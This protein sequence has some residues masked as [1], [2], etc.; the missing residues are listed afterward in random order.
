[1]PTQLPRPAAIQPEEYRQR[2][3]RL[4]AKLPSH[5]ALLVPGASLMTRSHDSEYPFRQQSD[6]YYL[7]GLQE[8][9]ALLLLLPGRAEGQSVVFCQ[10]RDPTLEAWTGRRLG[11]QGVVSQHGLDQAFENAE[12]DAL[13][14]TLLDGRELL[15]VPLDN[16]DALSIAEDALAYSQAGMRRGKPALKGWLDSRP[17][18][19]EM[20]LIKS[21]AE[22]ALLRHAAAI[23]AQAHVRAMRTCQ[24]G[25]SEYQLQA[26]LE[27]TFVWHGASGPAYSTIVGG[28]A[29]ACVLHYIENSD[30]LE[31]DTLVLIDAGAEFDLYAGDITRTFPVSGRFNDAQRALYQVVLDA[32][33]RAVNAIAPGATLAEIHQGVV[34]DLTAGLIELGLLSGDVQARIDDESYRRFYLHS[35]SHWLGLDVHDVGT[36][37]LDEATPRPLE[38]GMVL[39][40]EPGLY[41]PSDDDIPDAYRGIGI[42]IE[43]NV[44]VT[45]QGHDI[46]T[47]DVPKQVAD[48]EQLMANK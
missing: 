34:A 28:G 5:A 2:R 1:M 43:D 3:E 4:M 9:E 10:D 45:D 21:P 38:P 8:P 42:R 7:T 39:T 6:F 22:I 40:V 26:E 37:R 19:H 12:R 33:V 14:P 18:I 36:Y 24:A 11:A 27:H 48:I 30:V 23:S 29:N 35:T 25:L 17:L 44:V 31:E 20:R 41:I 47:A 13:L 46:L 15:Y 16:P 32:Q